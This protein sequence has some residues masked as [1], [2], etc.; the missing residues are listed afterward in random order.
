MAAR[1]RGTPLWVTIGCGCLLLIGLVIGG[2]V[3][4]GYFGVTS[5]KGYLEDME[6][7]ARRTARASEILGSANLPEGYSAQLFFRIPW[8]LDLVVLS[9]GQPM[10]VEDDGIDL[11]ADAIGEHLFTYFKY[12]KGKM[13]EDDIE[14]MLRGDRSAEGV[15]TDLG[16]ELES[17]E[18]ISRGSFEIEEQR[19]AYVA[20]RGEL[21]F[22]DGGM[23]GIY[24]QMIIDCPGDEVTRVAVW[25]RRDPEDAEEPSELTGS[26]ADEQALRSFMGHFNVC[27]D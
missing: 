27:I 5:F 10:V 11:E 7:P 17:E 18:E 22:D 15:K 14:R 1:Q 4:A 6:D 19:L 24:S 2:V 8:F 25:F 3:A 20:H 12:H 21:D 26:P 23:P 13:D 9:D 16:F